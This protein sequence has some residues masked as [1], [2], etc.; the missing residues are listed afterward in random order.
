L[1]LSAPLV[2]GD[3]IAGRRGRSW[4]SPISSFLCAVLV[5]LQ[6]MQRHVPALPYSCEV[7]RLH[8]LCRLLVIY[9]MALRPEWA[10]GFKGMHADQASLTVPDDC[11]HLSGKRYLRRRQNRL[12][13]LLVLV[14]YSTTS[15][16]STCTIGSARCI[17]GGEDTEARKRRTAVR[18]QKHCTRPVLF[19]ATSS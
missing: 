8:E 9:R 18:P 3:Y 4:P 1:I 14:S 11:A 19:S 6:V 15:T 17:E 2:R 7:E 16:L 10:R 13:V 12:S 5:C